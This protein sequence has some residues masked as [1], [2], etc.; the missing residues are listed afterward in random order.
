[1]AKTG[2]YVHVVP[3][4]TTIAATTAY[5]SGAA[6]WPITPAGEPGTLGSIE[7]HGTALAGAAILTLQ[8][9]RD[10]ALDQEVVPP[11]AVTLSTGVTTATAWSATVRLDIPWAGGSTLYLRVKTDAGTLT[12]NSAALVWEE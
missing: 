4:S 10:A 9:F 6:N 8:V 11:T 3:L 5:S 7:L 2:R 12:V 1:M